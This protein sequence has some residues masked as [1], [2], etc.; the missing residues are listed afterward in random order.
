MPSYW[1]IVE[2]PENWLVDQ[3][4]GFKRFGLK[5]RHRSKAAKMQPSDILITY[6]SGK[7][8]FSDIRRVIAPGITPLK[9]GGP[10]A[11][12]FAFAISTKPD[13]VLPKESWLPIRPL[14]A[15]LTFL[16]KTDWTQSFRNS[17]RELPQ[18]DGELL[19]REMRKVW[20][21]AKRASSDAE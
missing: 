5:E 13:L 6:V 9:L 19:A 16:S 20:K 10:Y 15:R 1:L 11:S 7:G 4:E 2:R 3:S 14:S 12:A 18:A 8:S 21:R 17:L